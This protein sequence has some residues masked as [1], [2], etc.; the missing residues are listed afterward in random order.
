MPRPFGYKLRES[1]KCQV[2][3]TGNWQYDQLDQRN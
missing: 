3:K 1:E 2:G